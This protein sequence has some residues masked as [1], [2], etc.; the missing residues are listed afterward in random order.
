ML[1]L[2]NTIKANQCSPQSSCILKLNKLLLD[3]A[4]GSLNLWKR[5]DKSFHNFETVSLSV[6]KNFDTVE[7]NFESVEKNFDT[8]GKN[9]DTVEKNF[10]TVVKNFD[11]VEKNFDTVEKNWSTWPASTS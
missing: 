10:E 11:T 3:V 7:K 6:K 8:V 1:K 5:N 2:K 9:F 4:Q